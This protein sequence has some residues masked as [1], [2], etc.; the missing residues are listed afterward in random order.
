MLVTLLIAVTK[1]PRKISLKGGLFGLP[2]RGVM[3]HDDG[4]GK[5]GGGDSRAH[6]TGT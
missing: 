1:S 2:A 4:G 5:G 3:V 6:Y